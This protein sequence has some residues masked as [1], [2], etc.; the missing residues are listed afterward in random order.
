MQTHVQTIMKQN[1][2]SENVAQWI[3]AQY[4]VKK[5]ATG[6]SLPRSQNCFIPKMCGYYR[7]RC[8]ACVNETIIFN[9]N[10]ARLAW[11]RQEARVMCR[12]CCQSTIITILWNTFFIHACI[13]DNKMHFLSINTFCNQIKNKHLVSSTLFQLKKSLFRMFNLD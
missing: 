7:S 5:P 2:D 10:E 6:D 3:N 12:V 13:H 1:M 8:V 11:R 4:Y 9:R